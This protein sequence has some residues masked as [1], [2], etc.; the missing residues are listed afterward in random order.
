ML[1][2]LY[3]NYVSRYRGRNIVKVQAR[4]IAGQRYEAELMRQD[5]SRKNSATM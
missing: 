2:A 1:I 4:F 5:A 3:Q